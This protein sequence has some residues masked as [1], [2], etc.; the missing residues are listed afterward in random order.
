MGLR[1][2]GRATMAVVVAVVSVALGAEPPPAEKQGG[3]SAAEKAPAQRRQTVVQ[4]GASIQA[5]RFERDPKTHRLVGVGNVLVVLGKQRVQCERM[6][7]QPPR[8]PD[9]RGRFLFEGKVRITIDESKVDLA[10]AAAWLPRDPDRPKPKRRKPGVVRGTCGRAE[11]EPATGRIVMKKGKE[12][13][14]P[15]LSDTRTYGEAD[16]IVLVLGKGGFELI[17]SPLINGRSPKGA[18]PADPPVS[19]KEAK[20]TKEEYREMLRRRIEA[21]DRARERLL[22]P[23]R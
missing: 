3:A 14:R 16:M 17:G 20:Q 18:L 13:Q 21:L 15:R 1:I 4:D 22:G 6:E 19:E 5:D 11:Y 7:W 12:P 23:T 10:F 9:G 8:E 2:V